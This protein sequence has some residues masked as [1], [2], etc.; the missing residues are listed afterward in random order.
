MLSDH[1]LVRTSP[2]IPIIRGGGFS[3]QLQQHQQQQHQQSDGDAMQGT[4]GG[5]MMVGS[6]QI[7]EEMLPMPM[8]QIERGAYGGRDVTMMRNNKDKAKKKKRTAGF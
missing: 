1:R 2:V 5:M 6:S 7:S 3:T 8:T 4:D